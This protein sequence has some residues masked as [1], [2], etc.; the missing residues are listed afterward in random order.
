MFFNPIKYDEPVF[1]PPS[2]GYS[3]ILQPTI[4]CS[5]N[6]CA[7]CEMYAS[8][9]FRVKSEE[10]IF[11]DIDIAANFSPNV[12]KVFLGDGNAMVLS[13]DKLL[14]IL[15][16]LNEKIKS[17]SRISAY[18]IPK[19]LKNK[20]VD[21]LRSLKEAGLKLIYVGIETGDDE[22]LG[23][24]NKGETA[25]SMIA[26]MQ[27][28]KEAGIKSSVMIIN[29]LGG[30]RYSGLHAVNSAKLI[31]AIQP[32]FLSTL[33]LSFPYGVGHFQQRFAGDFEEVNLLGL[34]HEQHTFI[35]N[36]DLESTIFRSDHASNYLV[37]KGILNRDKQLL[38]DQLQSAIDAPELANL[39][40]E[41]QRGL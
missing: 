17:L 3:L 6:R 29:G 9:K 28:A 5:W 25:E 31:N 21:E 16:Y 37:L 33:V 35:S 24:I 8:K 23:M 19:D 34:L 38:L 40:Q 18:A 12:R 36:L 20:T 41:W 13:T 39:R 27:K 1:R 15:N 26:S 10:E 22:L 11:S 30:K 32:E 4:G 2:E 7:F 14:N